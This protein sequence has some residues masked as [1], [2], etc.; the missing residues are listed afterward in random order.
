MTDK[1][2]S[3]DYRRAVLI[4]NIGAWSLRN[5]GYNPS[6]YLPLG[7]KVVGANAGLGPVASVLGVSEELGEFYG[8][9][10]PADQRDALADITIY[11][12]DLCHRQTISLNRA[13]ATGLW[14][15]DM[16]TLTAYDASQAVVVSVGQLSHTTLKRHQGIRGMD[17]DHKFGTAIAAAA[18]AVYLSVERCCWEG[19]EVNLLDLAE[20]TFAKI[21]GN[22][23]W[24]THP[25]TGGVAATDLG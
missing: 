1:I 8:A 10:N 24:L 18:A 19:H 15:A 23:D 17:D 5:F 22:R 6:P 12:C 20:E 11:L 3:N 7:R 21:V 25:A 14:P 4:S 13:I 2:E 16:K 9:D